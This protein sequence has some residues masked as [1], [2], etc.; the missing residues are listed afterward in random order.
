MQIDIRKELGGLGFSENEAAVYL[1]LLGLGS[2]TNSQIARESKLNRITNFE[3]LKRLSSRGIVSGFK[4]KGVMYFG[5]LNPQI[6]IKKHKEGL[7]ILEESL[8]DLVKNKN[9]EKRP[10][11]TTVSTREGLKQIYEESLLSKGEIL[12]FT[13]SK[14]VKEYFGGEYVDNYVRQR[15]KKGIRVRGFAPGGEVGEQDKREGEE[16]LREVRLIPENHRINNEIMIFDDKVAML[17]TKD[18]MGIIIKNQS[19]AESLR[20]V[21]KMLWEK[22]E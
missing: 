19:I 3:V 21:W 10:R 22:S 14:E 1:A 20:S 4:M 11:I 7:G 2:A 9:N 6:L 15:V 5:A 12:T 13:N 8:V 17:S 16:V 18:E